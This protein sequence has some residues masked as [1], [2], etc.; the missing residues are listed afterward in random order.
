MLFGHGFRCCIQLLFSRNAV[1]SRRLR[2]TLAEDDAAKASFHSFDSRKQKASVLAGVCHLLV[3]EHEAWSAAFRSRAGSAVAS[4][5]PNSEP[6]Q[7]EP[8]AEPLLQ[9]DADRKKTSSF[10]RAAATSALSD[11]KQQH[12]LEGKLLTSSMIISSKNAAADRPFSQ[13]H[14]SMEQACSA[15]HR[16]QQQSGSFAAACA[17][18]WAPLQR[19]READKLYLS[20]KF[21]KEELAPQD[22]RS[23]RR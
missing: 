23:P 16:T 20:K 9:E 4:S 10:L 18:L 12:E 5:I 1:A 17:H 6:A 21:S 14:S 11:L 7:H 15:G 2:S 22:V 8:A 13:R 19:N 3:A